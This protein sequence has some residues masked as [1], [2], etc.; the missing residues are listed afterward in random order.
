[1]IRGV[2]RVEEHQLRIHVV[3]HYVAG[4]IRET[5]IHMLVH[6][7]SKRL[8]PEWAEAF[9]VIGTND[10][11]LQAQP[12]RRGQGL[13]DALAGRRMS[14]GSFREYR[15]LRTALNRVKAG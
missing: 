8:V 14:A 12:Q 9:T 4:N 15:R 1:M 7:S 5:I 13:E 3:P 6:N 2:K 11:R 10:G